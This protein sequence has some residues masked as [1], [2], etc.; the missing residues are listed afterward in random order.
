MWPRPVVVDAMREVLEEARNT[1][2]AG[3][4]VPER[5]EISQEV[6]RRLA[7]R[8]RR[9]L[10]PVINAT[11]VILHTNLGRAPLSAEAIAAVHAVAA[12][13]SNLEYDLEAGTRG[14][15]DMFGSALLTRL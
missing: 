1:I 4:P 15:R 7:S 5:D 2:L 3:G 8:R 9:N 11:G 12:G 6:D 13:Y 14:S 10:R